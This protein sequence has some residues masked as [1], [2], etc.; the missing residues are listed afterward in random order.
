MAWDWVVGKKGRFGTRGGEGT[1]EKGMAGKETVMEYYV[2]SLDANKLKAV[3]GLDQ[4][5][6]G[7]NDRLDGGR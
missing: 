4:M 1:R 3:A 7:G 5:M 2:N 6:G